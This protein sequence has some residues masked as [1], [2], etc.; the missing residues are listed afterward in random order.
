MNIRHSE[1]ADIAQI[2][3]IYEQTVNYANTLQ[4]P[5]PSLDTWESF[6][7]EKPENFYSLIATNDNQIVGQIGIEV[8]T[9]PRRK[10]VAN[11][12]MA[13]LPD[14]CNQGIGSALLKAAIELLENWLAVTRIELEVYT[15]NAHAVAL[16]EKFGFKKEGTAKQYA[17]RNGEYVDVFLMARVNIK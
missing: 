15:D 17:F 6:L 1:K 12:G 14:K 11:I 13:V 5:Y 4:L 3:H 10:H 8:F 16:Y 9:K 7:A 2:K